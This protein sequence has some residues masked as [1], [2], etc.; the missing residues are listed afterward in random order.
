MPPPTG[1]Q[2]AP[3]VWPGYVVKNRDP[4][5]AGRIVAAVPGLW[6]ETP[7]WC[8]PLGWQDGAERAR[9]L[10][11][12]PAVKAPVVLQFLYGD[13]NEGAYYSLGAP[14]APEG[15]TAVPTPLVAASN[16]EERIGTKVLHEDETFVVYSTV[17]SNTKL[18]RLHDK[19][20]GSSITLDSAGGTSGKA[21]GIVIEGE[22]DIQISSTYGRIKLEAPRIVINGRLVHGGEDSI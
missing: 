19:R 14:G 6:E 13:P 11:R 18:L 3:G 9:G 7:Y 22:T 1:K 10:A 20:T 4:K 8:L 5:E 16:W 21:G 17:T 15:I 2:Y 12:I